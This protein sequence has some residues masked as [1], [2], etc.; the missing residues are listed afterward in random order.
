MKTLAVFLT[1]IVTSGNNLLAQTAWKEKVVGKWIYAGTEEFGVL[2]PADS[3]QVK[4]WLTINADGTYSASEKGKETKGTYR[5]DDTSKTI[6]FK[7]ASGKSTLY[8][9]K[10]SD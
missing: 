2:K 5:I 6:T 8:Y 1:L 3:T 10:K 7:D 4:D 9:L